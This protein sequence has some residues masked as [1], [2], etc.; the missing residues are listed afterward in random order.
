[1]SAPQPPYGAPDSAQLAGLVFELASQLHVER[2]RR[3]A[4]E[5][6]LADAGVLCAGAVEAAGAGPA[7]A[8]AAAQGLDRA[9]AALM[10]V[11]T[12]DADERTPLRAQHAR[13]A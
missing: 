6:A 9:M 11:L 2:C 3:M 5:A 4:L 8:P 7:F 1:M 12:E 13:S 10:R